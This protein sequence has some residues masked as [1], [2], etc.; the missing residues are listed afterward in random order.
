MLKARKERI[1]ELNRSLKLVQMRSQNF[2]EEGSAFEGRSSSLTETGAGKNDA[3][4]SLR[5]ARDDHMRVA[6]SDDGHVGT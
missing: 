3:A 5:E 6:V 4:H 2:G 1:R